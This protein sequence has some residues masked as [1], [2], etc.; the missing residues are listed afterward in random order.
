[1][2]RRFSAFMFATPLGDERLKELLE[3]SAAMEKEAFSASIDAYTSFNVESRMGEIK[4][5]TLVIAADR[6]RFCNVANLRRTAGGING[7]RF[8]VFEGN[9]HCLHIESPK[10]FVDLLTGFIEDVNRGQ[11]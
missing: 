9:N 10:R 5:P 6:D 2:W 8:E 1:M 11:A 3:Y 7:S 4:L